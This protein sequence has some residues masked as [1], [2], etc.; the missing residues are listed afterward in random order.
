MITST[1]ILIQVSA[2]FLYYYSLANNLI[3]FLTSSKIQEYIGNYG[4]EEFGAQLL[5]PYIEVESK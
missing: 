2:L 1:N 3:S 5:S 4:I